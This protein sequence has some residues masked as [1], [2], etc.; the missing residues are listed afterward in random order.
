[1][2]IT[3]A[4]IEANGWVLQVTFN[5]TPSSAG[6]FSQYTLDPN[7]TPRLMLAA[8]ASG[9]TQ[10]SGVAVASSAVARS[11]VATKPLRKVVNATNAGARDA[12]TPDETNL[13]GGLVRI[14]IALSQHIYATDTG[15]TLAALAGWRTG[16]AASSGIAV[17][18]NS[19]L[20]APPPILRWSDVPYQRKTGPF[21][22]EVVA[23]SHH[24]SGL[25][26]I[27]AVR[28]TATDGT[29]T[30]TAWATALSTSTRYGDA[31]RVYKVTIDGSTAIP[32]ALTEGLVRCD[33][34]A[35][36]WIGPARASNTLDTAATAVASSAAPSMS[37]LTTAGFAP[38]AQAPFVIAYDPSAT[39][40]PPL[41]VYIAPNTFTGTGAISGTTLTVTAVAT[42]ALTVGTIISG[43]GIT[44]ATKI[45]ALGSGSG[46]TGTYT[47]SVS[48]T[49]A[50]TAT[51][52]GGGNP[53]NNIVTVSANAATAGNG[54]CADSY[55]CA[56]NAMKI[57]NRVVAARNGQAASAAGATDG[58][59]VRYKAGSYTGL[60]AVGVGTGISTSYTWEIVEG[61]PADANPRGN[62]VVAQATSGNTRSTRTLVR[63]LTIIGPSTANFL[64]SPYGWIDNVEVRGP[65]GNATNTATLF[66]SS[67][68][69]ATYWTRSR[70]WQ[71]GSYIGGPLVRACEVE[72][73]IAATVV[74]TSRRLPSAVAATSAIL[75]SGSTAD[76]LGATQDVIISGNDLRYVKGNVTWSE[77]LTPNANA[78]AAA[79]GTTYPV[80]S[81][82]VFANNV[83]ESYGASNPMFTCVGEN[84]PVVATYNIIE[85]NTLSGDRTNFLYDDLNFANSPAT[86]YNTKNDTESNI[87]LCNR[88][89][90]NA[91]D[92][93]SLKADFFNDPFVQSA[94][95][96]ASDPR[97]HGYRPQAIRGW[98]ALYGVNFADN[99]I[100]R[101]N[102]TLLDGAHEFEGLN[103]PNYTIETG[104]AAD[105]KY[106]LD[107]SGT[108]ISGSRYD[109]ANTGGG[110]YKP[111]AGSP[112]NGHA[113]SAS[114]DVDQRGVART[115]PFAAGAVQNDVAVAI[116]PA[117]TRHAA[118]ASSPALR[119]AATLAAASTVMTTRAASGRATW[120]V[121]LPVASA[122]VA[123]RA[124]AGSVRWN[125]TLAAAS[126][127]IATRAAVGSV[128]WNAMLAAASGQIVTREAMGS[129]RWSATLA[130]ASGLV[131]T[132]AAS[133]VAGW[134]ATLA[135]N[136][137]RMA[138]RAASGLAGW[139]AT[140]V[141]N[142]TRMATR[143]AP[144]SIGWSAMLVPDAARLAMLAATGGIGWMAVLVPASA[145]SA[146]AASAAAITTTGPWALGPANCRHVVSDRTLPIILPGSTAPPD[147]TLV[148]TG[149][150]RTML[151]TLDQS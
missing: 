111:L 19:T 98:S 15:L 148:V 44:A 77:A 58:M 136:A 21:D 115:I 51:L 75:A 89:A 130:A 38:A 128:R 146:S 100:L 112:L 20:A 142:A 119:W 87:I 140:L 113:F 52:N 40:L 10:S 145:R 41:Y 13:G 127:Q 45:T 126:G 116:V 50:S 81:R 92:Q 14:R 131:V 94:R 143:A 120:S 121:A 79:M 33:Y 149:D 99:V 8:A 24:P 59:V 96:A 125:A 31:L 37:S 62:I 83:C 23:F 65:S 129:V 134:S 11:L 101:G 43:T 90:N 1:M 30:A 139:S 3:S 133:G 97:Q 82:Q 109:P 26:P 69:L 12:K 66:N 114:V 55:T 56:R 88:I 9:F 67:G 4:S 137:A 35:F 27:A 72:N 29:N 84:N 86:T 150:F 106:T 28:F 144:G 48:Q 17:T 32:G 53:N 103:S 105:P 91:F 22:L 34:K 6:D 73:G 85:G 135:P 95:A 64:T 61:D 2:A 46:G 93:H 78:G 16:E 110:D 138:T 18:N 57:Q 80:F 36:P 104:A 141:P 76:P 42:G 71:I 124:A 107:K 147:R 54:T 123:T 5:G 49:A 117:A 60:G 74:V 102:N 70:Y 68:S 122:L 108:D 63:N 7:G 39:W 25:A 47:V 118:E 151:V 132:R